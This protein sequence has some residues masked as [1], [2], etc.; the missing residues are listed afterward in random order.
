MNVLQPVY[1]NDVEASSAVDIDERR[2]TTS[3]NDSKR[4]GLLVAME[5]AGVL[6]R[7][8]AVLNVVESRLKLDIAQCVTAAVT[9]TGTDGVSKESTSV[10]ISKQGAHLA[11]LCVRQRC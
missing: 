9:T 2:L 6:S 5:G 11:F 1:G 10:V 3:L 8:Y 4:A 7:C